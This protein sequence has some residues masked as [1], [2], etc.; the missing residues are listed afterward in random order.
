M[1]EC[2]Y[3][4]VGDGT[5]IAARKTKA[6]PIATLRVDGESCN[7]LQRRWRIRN[8]GGLMMRIPGRKLRGCHLAGKSNTSGALSGATP[9]AVH[10]VSTNPFSTITTTTLASM[11]VLTFFK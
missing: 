7:C 2:W 11:R 9:W 8:A 1:V 6:I 3:D 5:E 4:K 10:Y